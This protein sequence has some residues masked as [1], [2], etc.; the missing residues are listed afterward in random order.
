MNYKAHL[1]IILTSIILLV[2][3]LN[4]LNFPIVS[5]ISFK[6]GINWSELNNYDLGLILSLETVI[7][8]FIYIM[9]DIADLFLL[10]VNI[11]GIQRN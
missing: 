9:Y 2:F 1:Y 6:W 7:L 4:P 11:F 10:N 8:S 5:L 3:C